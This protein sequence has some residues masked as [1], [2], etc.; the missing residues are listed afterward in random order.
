MI[1]I[2]VVAAESARMARYFI[3]FLSDNMVDTV[4]DNSR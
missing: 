2:I 3:A 1:I 4:G